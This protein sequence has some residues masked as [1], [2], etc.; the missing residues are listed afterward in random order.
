MVL[1]YI[2]DPF[3]GFLM[4]CKSIVSFSKTRG[5]HWHWYSQQKKKSPKRK[6][7]REKSA[8]IC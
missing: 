2:P 1:L 8:P 4:N 3:A 6:H 7:K 5:K